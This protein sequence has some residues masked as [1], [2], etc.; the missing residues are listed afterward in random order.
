MGKECCFYRSYAFPN[1]KRYVAIVAQ[2]WAMALRYKKERQGRFGYQLA[3]CRLLSQARLVC[4]NFNQFISWPVPPCELEIIHSTANLP[5][6]L[7]KGE[8]NFKKGK[9]G[10]NHLSKSETGRHISANAD[11][12]RDPIP[13]SC[14]IWKSAGMAFPSHKVC[15]TNHHC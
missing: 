9:T 6:D 14:F 13:L 7:V 11:R 5:N 4:W 12:S 15:Y 8:K 10:T 1:E 3:G 2:R